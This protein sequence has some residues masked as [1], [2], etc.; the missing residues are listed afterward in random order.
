MNFDEGVLL[1]FPE[2]LLGFP[3]FTRLKLMEPPDDYPFKFLRPVD[4]E[5]VTFIALDIAA[6]KPDFEVPLSPLEAE[7]LAI[8][9]PED[10]MVLT[11]VVIPDDMQQMFTNLA[12]P[13]VINIRARVGRQIALVGDKYPLR[14]PILEDP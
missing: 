12:G 2:G 7:A 4:R 10:A 3:A 8:G 5:E 13:L 9:K 1:E 11:L 6:I 14:F